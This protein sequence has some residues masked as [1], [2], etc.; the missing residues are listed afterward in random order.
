MRPLPKWLLPPLTSLLAGR[1]RLHHALL[2]TGPEGVGKEWLARA[3]AAAL[4]CDAPGAARLACGGCAGC[5]WF[6]QNS[7]PDFRLIRPS[8]D[9]VSADDADA[10]AKATKASRDIRIEQIR[11]LAGF[12]EIASHRGGAKVVLVTPAEA[13]NGAAANALLKTLEEPSPNTYFILVC[14]RI[15]RLPLTVRSRCRQVPIRVPSTNETI[16]WVADQTGVDSDRALEWLAFCGGAPRRAVEFGM[17]EQAA[18]HRDLLDIVA[19][20]DR[21]TLPA[22][23]DR[24]QQHEPGNWTP[25]LHAWCVDLLRCKAGALPRYFPGETNRLGALAQ[26]SDL[27]GL[28]GF[29]S[30]MRQLGRLVTH[31]LNARLVAEDALS[32]YR[33]VFARGG[34]KQ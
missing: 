23:A 14:S 17:A 19:S 26:R 8:A 7:H 3:L 24:L 18:T 12:V 2:I 30:W 13:M 20:G 4:L 22:L 33:A 29:E 21:D 9:E 10:P 1:E 25:V 11:A 15:Y 32:R 5:R 28:I 27:Q 34:H 6:S 31:P 16:S